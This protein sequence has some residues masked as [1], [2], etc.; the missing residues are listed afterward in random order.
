MDP[1]TDKSDRLAM[2]DQELAD[3]DLPL[4]NMEGFDALLVTRGELIGDLAKLAAASPSP[5]IVDILRRSVEN[6]T[7]LTQNL[8]ALRRRLGNQHQK[9]EL[10]APRK[11]ASDHD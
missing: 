7:A 2:L 5:A 11:L 8:A 6:G 1:A 10:L 9:L 4:E 3:Y